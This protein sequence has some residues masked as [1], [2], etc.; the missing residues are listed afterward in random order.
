LQD[1]IGLTILCDHQGLALF[2]EV[3]QDLDSDGIP[4][5]QILEERPAQ[6]N[7]C[8]RLSKDLSK[9]ICKPAL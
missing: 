3:R 7:A 1:S 8:W 2:S 9:T 4:L 6:E 5:Q